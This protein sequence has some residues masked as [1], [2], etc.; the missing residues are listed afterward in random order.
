MARR[1]GVLWLVCALA[2]L[3]VGAVYLVAP[4]TLPRMMNGEDWGVAAIALFVVNAVYA[5]VAWLYTWSYRAL[6]RSQACFTLKSLLPTLL[7]DAPLLYVAGG[8]VVFAASRSRAPLETWDEAIGVI[9]CIAA[10][11]AM[12]STISAWMDKQPK[13]CLAAL[14]SA[15]IAFSVIGLVLTT[16]I[17]IE[18]DAP[19]IGPEN[20]I[21][22]VDALFSFPGLWMSIA[23]LRCLKTESAARNRS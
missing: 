2:G 13:L 21:L 7:P 4:P 6:C 18:G 12:L 17:V 19:D 8:F 5:A 10:V 1:L 15:G 11:C 16:R 23:F 22:L 3:I 20:G 14:A 9:V